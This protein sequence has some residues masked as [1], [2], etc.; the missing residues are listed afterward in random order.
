[1]FHTLGIG[2][3]G[4]GIRSSVFRAIRSFFVSERAICSWKRANH[5]HCYFVMSDLSESIFKKESMSKQRR[6]RFALGHKK[7]ENVRKTV[8]N[9]WKILIFRANHSHRSFLKSNESNSL[10]IMSNVDRKSK[11]Q[12]SE[13]PT[14]G[15]TVLRTVAFPHSK[16][17]LLISFMERTYLNPW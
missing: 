12:M 2:N 16:T 14:L 3:S 13:F 10:F 9:I 7:G 15:H 17:N 4:L 8:K 1:M 6:E 11:E 5:S